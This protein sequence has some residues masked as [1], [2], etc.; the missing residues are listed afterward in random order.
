MLRL[1]WGDFTRATRSKTLPHP[2]SSTATI[3]TTL[4]SLLLTEQ[5][6]IRRRGLTL[7]G[8]S[9][10]N[11]STTRDLQLELP[12]EGPT[13]QA[14]DTTI[15]AIRDR[16]GTSTISRARLLNTPTRTSAWLM[17]DDTPDTIDDLFS[18]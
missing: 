5:E 18:R 2:T 16:F 9:I 3:L 7:L 12:L 11:L 13:H 4:R 14:L 1:R 6:S 17:P 15:D 10:T 8:L